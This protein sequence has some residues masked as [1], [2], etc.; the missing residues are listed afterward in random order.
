M[1]AGGVLGLE[2]RHVE[3]IAQRIETVPARKRREFGAQLGHIG[4]R[5]RLGRPARHPTGYANRPVISGSQLA[6]PPGQNR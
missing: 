1:L 5:L 2:P 6:P 3:D 4:S